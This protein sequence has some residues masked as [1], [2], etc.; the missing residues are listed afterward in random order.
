[1][2]TKLNWLKDTYLVFSVYKVGHRSA[3]AFLCVDF[4][5]IFETI[6]K[7]SC[8]MATHLKTLKKS[9]QMFWLD[10]IT[11]RVYSNDLVRWK[12]RFIFITDR[13]VKCSF[14]YEPH[15][16]ISFK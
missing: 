4:R 9:L 12:S 10:L 2:F 15:M 3:K 5:F 11:D 1:M 13:Q 7:I 6:V 8:E 14:M 16:I